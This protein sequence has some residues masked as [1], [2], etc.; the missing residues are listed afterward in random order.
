[1]D[2][3]PKFRLAHKPPA[4]VETRLKRPQSSGGAAAS[5]APNNTDA[6]PA[7]HPSAVPPTSSR[8]L[9][10]SNS[11]PHLFLSSSQHGQKQEEEGA[12]PHKIHLKMPKTNYFSKL[13]RDRKRPRESS[14]S[15][16]PVPSPSTDAS[17][18][19]AASA[20]P[21]S[22]SNSVH[23]GT[24]RTSS[25]D[26]QRPGSHSEPEMRPKAKMPAFLSS[27]KHGMTML[28]FCLDVQDIDLAALASDIQRKYHELMWEERN[29]GMDGTRLTGDANGK[30]SV[31][32]PS[33]GSEK[34]VMDR[35]NNIK[36]WD[37]NR[38]KLR[39][40]ADKADYVNASSITLASQSDHGLP[41]LRYIAM[42]GPTLPSI[43]HVWRMIAE[44]TV[45]AA[46]IV[47]LTTMTE[48]YQV[49][50]HQYFPPEEASSWTLNEDDVWSD[51]WKAHLT[52]NSTEMLDNGA[53]EKRKLTFQIEGERKK[54]SR[55]VWHFL[56][57]CWPDFGVPRGADLQAFFH[58]MSLS[59]SHNNAANPTIVHCSAGVGR[60]GTFISLEYLIR[61]LDNGT[62]RL[63]D[64]PQ[65]PGLD[66]AHQVVDT[67][68]Q[69]RKG[70]VQGER[71][72]E[73]IYVVLRK[74]W[75][76]KYGHSSDPAASDEEA[77]DVADVF[78][79]TPSSSSSALP[80]Q[81]PQDDDE[82]DEVA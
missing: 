55:V 6:A 41:D 10:H 64:S 36:P 71:Q 29:R 78:M 2:K 12:S 75:K 11:H 17:H 16:S 56:F 35:Y 52:H 72:F 70:M 45:S 7:A 53:I 67:L 26:N 23:T 31:Y 14:P 19:S 76:E 28:S 62:F 13:R 32:R 25:P 68:R 21:N 24:P 30:W 46:V 8:A 37:Y 80:L 82:D 49:K 20:G 81:P 73:F 54:Q 69:Q 9:S 39:V 57:T 63:Y 1:M 27:T 60:T 51:G 50:C 65:K 15:T 44:Q 58:L 40:P 42:Q 34:S 47:Q 48:N 66:M 61:E 3:L 77:E 4:G 43:P 5:I 22:D 79:T 33:D 18:F 38:V 59:R 74:L